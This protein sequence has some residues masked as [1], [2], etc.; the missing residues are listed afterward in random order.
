[1]R[2]DESNSENHTLKSNEIKNKIK[3]IKGNT[4]LKQV[5]LG[6]E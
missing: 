2:S 5:R 1:M 6:G 4:K 3:L